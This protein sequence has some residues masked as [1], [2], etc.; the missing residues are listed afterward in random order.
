MD[1]IWLESSQ[2]VLFSFVSVSAEVSNSEAECVLC[3]PPPA[4]VLTIS[5]SIL[6]FLFCLPLRK[7]LHS[8]SCFWE[9]TMAFLNVG[10]ASL[11]V[12]PGG[13]S[14][15]TQLRRRSVVC[16]EK[17][18]ADDEPMFERMRTEDGI[19]M[20]REQVEE[21]SPTVLYWNEKTKSVERFA[22]VITSLPF[23]ALLLALV[24]GALVKL[25]N[26]NGVS[27]IGNY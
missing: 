21:I 15:C 27:L 25:L 10:V 26:D 7:D 11:R 24:G 4:M 18:T 22:P 23:L 16:S 19:E 8:E 3:L 20:E 5:V 14:S 1:P 2:L 17:P 9:G 6:A 12:S 13:R